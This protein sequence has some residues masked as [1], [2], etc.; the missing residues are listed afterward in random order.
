MKTLRIFCLALVAL[1]CT[2]PCL[3]QK[4]KDQTSSICK[5]HRE[6]LNFNRHDV[7]FYAC[8]QNMNDSLFALINDY[9]INAHDGW[10]AGTGLGGFHIAVPP[11]DSLEL[12]R[13]VRRAI[14]DG[15]L[16]ATRYMPVWSTARKTETYI[17]ED[18]QVD[19][20]TSELYFSRIRITEGSHADRHRL[21][22]MDGSCFSHA[23]VEAD[24]QHRHRYIVHLTLTQDGA[25]QCQQMTRRHL[26]ENMVFVLGSA[27]FTI[28]VANEVGGG[29]ISISG[30]TLE[31]ACALADLY[32]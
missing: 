11:K 27:S 15:K 30:L 8:M 14:A 29:R 3:A 32:N 19:I 17:I 26:H 7:A 6:H 25:R 5:C 13:L 18:K 21:A 1:V 31:Q 24:S 16:D 28:H 20:S 2:T 12:D 23:E 9:N 10:W 4:H 22:L